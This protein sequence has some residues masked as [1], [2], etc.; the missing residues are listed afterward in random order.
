MISR[1]LEIGERLLLVGSRP[2]SCN[3]IGF[4][5]WQVLAFILCER[6]LVDKKQFSRLFAK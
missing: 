1:S 5:E 4:C 6:E 3:L 2:L